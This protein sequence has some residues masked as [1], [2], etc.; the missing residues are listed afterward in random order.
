MTTTIL[1][2]GA[3]DG[4][5]LALARH[6]HAQGASLCLVGRRPLADLD[7]TLFTSTSYCQADL[8]DP[9]A[10]ARIVAWLVNR[11]TARLD[12]VLHNAGVGWYGPPAQQTAESIDTL[13]QVNVVAP[14]ALTHAVRRT[15]PVKQVVFIASVA[16]NAPAPLYAVYAASKAALAG[17]ARSWRVETGGQPHIQVIYLGAV[18]TA[19]HAKSGVPAGT[20][21]TAR[22][23]SAETAARQVA[24]AVAS[25]SSEI[26]P[27]FG[28]AA[29]RWLSQHWP[30]LTEALAGRRR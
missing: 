19:M 10:P 6:Y 21:N 11:P 9:A 18:R 14:L 25:R 13:L 23:P 8:S 22:F 3:T 30:G 15:L 12:V 5:G 28:N 20:F 2:T 24:R 27:G 7:P 16:A 26:T 17:F 29:L 4:L 1:I